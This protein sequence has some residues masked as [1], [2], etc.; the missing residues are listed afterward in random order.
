MELA[1]LLPFLMFFCLLGLILTGFPV[2]FTLM[3]TALVFGALGWWLDL[4]YFS[5]FAF[6]PARIFGIMSN[7]TLMAVPLFVFMGV[8]LEK[9]QLAEEL[10]RSM[11]RLCGRLR[12][13]MALSVIVVGMLLAAATGI[14]GATVVT[15]GVLSLPAMMKR[16]YS[17]E[18]V[19]GT[20][21]ASG[22]LGQI[23]PPSIVL[24]LL[25]DIMNV[26]VGDLFTGALL[27]GLLLVGLYAAYV[28]GRVVLQPELAPLPPADETA[29]TRGAWREACRSL[30][31]TAGLIVIVLG[32][33]F[34]G[35]ASPTEAAAC[36]ALGATLISL[37]KGRLRLSV[38]RSVMDETT[39]TTTM[40]FMILIGAQFFGVVF[41]GLAGD[42]IITDLI[43]HM[44]VSPHLVLLL[45]LLLLFVLGF[46][47]DFFEVCFIVLP[48]VTPLLIS[49][50]FS[51]IWLAVL[52]GINLQTSFLTPPFG[53]ALFYLKGVAPP[54][55]TTAQ[56]YRGIIPFVLLQLL[57]LAIVYF[58]PA[59]VLW[60]PEKVF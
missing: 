25:G 2:A 24:V 55:I 7:I 56:I 22:T 19:T 53:F 15:M 52:F 59:I 1:T 12:G 6:V 31:P 47:L 23:I 9:S 58:Y 34:A 21:A 38:L 20:I 48:I 26:D 28:L 35:M 32:S 17:H 41:R 39:T 16:K 11:E 37:L 30:L 29:D 4:F 49:L 45:V 14:V 40:V 8:M 10:L 33:I 51:P 54:E 13:G 44:E 27:P 3:G 5:D 57:G 60:L 43:T 46:F 18:L 36:G 42:Q 50:G